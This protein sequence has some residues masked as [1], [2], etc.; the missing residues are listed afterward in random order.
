MPHFKARVELPQIP[1]DMT[2]EEFMLDYSHKLRPVR[3]AG[4]PWLVV[5]KTGRK[6]GLDEIRTR[7]RG[8]EVGV[9]SQFGIC[10]DD[11]VLIF[12]KNHIDY[13]ICV[14]AMHRLL[15]RVSLCNPTFTNSELGHQV[16][17]TKPALI[18]AHADVLNTAIRGAREF[19]LSSDRVVVLTDDDHAKY[20]NQTTV[21]ELIAKGLSLPNAPFTRKLHPGEGRKKIALLSPS[22]GTTG[23]PKVVALSHFGLIAGVLMVSSHQMS[24]A[25]YATWEERRYRPGDISLGVVPLYHIFGVLMSHV[26]LFCAI[27][28]VVVP[29]FVFKEMLNSIVK[30]EINLLTI[31]PPQAVMLSKDPIVRQYDLTSVR[32]ITCG[33]ASLSVGLTTQLAQLFPR[34]YI[35]QA[36]GQTEV[37]GGISMPSMST[38]VGFFCGT[39]L[40]GIIARVVKSDGA[41]A[42]HNEPGELHVKSPSVAV[43]YWGNEIA[44]RE[45]FMD[46]WART[47][48]L[49]MF[50]ANEEIVY[51]D[52]LKEIIKVNGLQVSPAELEGCLHDHPMVADVCVVG[53]P[54]EKTGEVPLAFVVLTSDAALLSQEMMGTEKIKQE[55]IQ[56]VAANKTRYK[57]VARVEFIDSIPRNPSGKMLHHVL[58]DKALQ[59][60]RSD[61]KL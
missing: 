15:A 20:P 39:L 1:D 2:L 19:G 28:V 57:H 30:H 56:H 33:G 26:P 36:Y 16:R 48:D 21:D 27:T 60:G 7:T 42:A 5:D 38:K 14:W 34:A 12:S 58:R 54:N 3:P 11:V 37:T 61:A 35:G 46:G 29:K 9:K 32:V 51:I 18:I 8:L 4:T 22:S 24:D 50:N 55:L 10:E 43:G 47:G 44:T 53:L 49:V 13:L 41:L 45:T 17:Q 23:L 25:K 52:R 40:P 6:V 59:M 31:V